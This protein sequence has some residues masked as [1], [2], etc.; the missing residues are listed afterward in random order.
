MKRSEAIDSIQILLEKQ[1]HYGTSYRFK[2]LEILELIEKLDMC[3][4]MSDQHGNLS[5]LDWEPE[6]S[7]ETKKGRII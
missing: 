6:D 7:E 5:S 2:A 4:V 1:S 3:P